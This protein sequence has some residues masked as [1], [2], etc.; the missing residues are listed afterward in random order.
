MREAHGAVGPDAD[1]LAP[2]ETVDVV[3]VALPMAHHLPAVRCAAV[4]RKH[5]ISEKALSVYVAE[6]LLAVEAARPRV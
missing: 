5:V 2:M 1:S 4:H 6:A 3:Y